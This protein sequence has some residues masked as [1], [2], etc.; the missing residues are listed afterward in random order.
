M[1]L[2]FLSDELA[3]PLDRKI[4]AAAYVDDM[5]PALREFS[6]HR[7]NSIGNFHGYRKNTMAIRL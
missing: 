5:M 4:Q 2:N 3:Q 6:G 7:R 1:F